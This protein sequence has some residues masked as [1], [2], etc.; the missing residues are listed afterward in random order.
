M[1]M[2]HHKFLEFC[3]KI[4]KLGHKGQRSGHFH[5]HFDIPTLRQ[6]HG[7]TSNVRFPVV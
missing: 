7:V 3:D 6:K 5:T 1:Y 4:S 2:L